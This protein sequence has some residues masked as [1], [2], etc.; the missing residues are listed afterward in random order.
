MDIVARVISLNSLSK[1]TLEMSKVGADKVGI[2]IMSKKS[3]FRAVKLHNISTIAANILKQEM[4]SCGGDVV[5]SYGT[6]NHSTEKTDVIILGLLS[7]YEKLIEKLKRQQFGLPKI[8]ELI[9][10]TLQNYDTVPRAIKNLNFGN[11]TIVMG[12][13]NVTPDSFSDGGKYN[14]VD[15]A[16]QHFFDMVNDGAQIIDIGGESTRP[17]AET[18]DPQIEIDR[19]LPVLKEVVE[20][21]NNLEEKPLISIDTRKS[22][23]AKAALENGADIINDISGLSFD[24]EMA[25]IV[26]QFDAP[27]IIMHSKGDPKTMQLNP[28]YDD[29]MYEM[30]SFFEQKI[31]Y[32]CKEGIK[33][34]NIIIDPGIGFGKTVDHNLTILK[35]L[36]EFRKF[37]RPICLG[38]SRKSFLGKILNI[39]EPAQ[40][41]IATCATISLAISK[42]VDIIRVHNTKMAMQAVLL[43]DKIFREEN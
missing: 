25:S 39:E 36:E 28:H 42:K 27:I 3:I 20:K 15:D 17:G 4:L 1:A 40:R 29:L 43:L 30:L 13:L 14:N 7:Q 18:V 16:V 11:C 35:N 21:C 6:I 38:T 2:D 34:D 5:T 31:S 33:E 32:A 10:L 8:S 24:E 41:D 19:I 9:K 26:A 37:N 23:V 22:Q 12:I